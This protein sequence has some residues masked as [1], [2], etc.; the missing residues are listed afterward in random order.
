MDYQANNMSANVA[1]ELLARV[2]GVL[3]SSW[4]VAKYSAEQA[5]ALEVNAML[6]PKGWVQK[7]IRRKGRKTQYLLWIDGRQMGPFYT[8]TAR[9]NFITMTRTLQNAEP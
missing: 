8:M 4:R 7:T 2:T 1:K 9:K 6:H 3:N 5:H